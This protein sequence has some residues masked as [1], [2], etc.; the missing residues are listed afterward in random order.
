MSTN[1]VGV[2][3]LVNPYIQKFKGGCAYTLGGGGGGGIGYFIKV[4]TSKSN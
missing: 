2:V 4:R 1:Y 3:R